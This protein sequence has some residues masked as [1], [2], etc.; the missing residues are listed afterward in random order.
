MFKKRF[1][2]FNENF[3]KECFNT[4]ITACQ[5]QP[6][7]L[8]IL[9]SHALTFHKNSNDELVPYLVS[10]WNKEEGEVELY[11]DEGYN[12]IEDIAHW[13]DIALDA[14]MSKAAGMKEYSSTWNTDAMLDKLSK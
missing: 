5:T 3:I 4:I 12:K 8:L 1:Q 2:E 13:A 6:H 11:S 10:V 9:G 7:N 14:V